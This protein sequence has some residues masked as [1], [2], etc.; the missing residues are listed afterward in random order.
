MYLGAEAPFWDFLRFPLNFISRQFQEF[1]IK[2]D[3][4]RGSRKLLLKK[5]HFLHD[6]KCRSNGLFTTPGVSWGMRD[7]CWLSP[8]SLSLQCC[9]F[10]LQYYYSRRRL[11]SS[12]IWT[13]LFS[14]PS[15]CL[16]NVIQICWAHITVV[17]SG[18][19]WPPLFN[20]LAHCIQNMDIK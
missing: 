11:E 13:Q 12:S 2:G 20:A 5:R 14:L 16:R 6:D 15:N 17:S 10:R 3:K 19:H 4:K 9:H 18:L 7:D 1:G 8:F